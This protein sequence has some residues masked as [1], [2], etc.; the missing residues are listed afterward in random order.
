MRLVVSDGLCVFKIS[1]LG[2]MMI[3]ALFPKENYYQV[4]RGGRS[5]QQFVKGFDDEPSNSSSGTGNA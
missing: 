4:R 1:Q 2:D 5:R 3:K